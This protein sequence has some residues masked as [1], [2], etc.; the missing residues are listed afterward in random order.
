VRQAIENWQ[1]PIGNTS[2][3]CAAWAADIR[4]AESAWYP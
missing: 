4:C 2:K 1:P 3:L